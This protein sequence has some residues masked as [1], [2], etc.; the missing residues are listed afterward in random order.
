MPLVLIPF[1]LLAMPVLEIAVFITVGKA[2]GVWPTIGLVLLSAVVGTA[3][4]RRE[5]LKAYTRV[6]SELAAGR[7]PGRGIADG[8]M[9]MA[10]GLLLLTPGFVTDT[11]GLLLFVEPVR[12]AIWRFVSRR[13]VVVGAGAF[14]QRGSR[15]AAAPSQPGRP[16]V[17]D[18]GEGDFIRKPDATSPWHGGD[19][20]PPPPNRTLH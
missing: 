11:I 12:A 15:G 5:G 7:L 4:L 1:L 8:F 17:I 14:N 2:I 10:A 18:L 13:I 6:Q 19:D 9:V 20:V 3:L 16:D